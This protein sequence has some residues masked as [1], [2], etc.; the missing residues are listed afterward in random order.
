M[1][2]YA[3]FFLQDKYKIYFPHVVF[4]F[5][6]ISRTKLS[7]NLNFSDLFRKFL[8]VRENLKKKR[9]RKRRKIGECTQ[10]REI[11]E[12]SRSLNQVKLVDFRDSYSLCHVAVKKTVGIYRIGGRRK[13]Y[14]RSLKFSDLYNLL[15]SLISILP[16]LDT[17]HE[18][19]QCVLK[20]SCDSTPI[21][22][23]FYLMTWRQLW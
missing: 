6:Y 5:S 10:E 1:A 22:V 13:G 23:S 15:K 19:K 2:F 14:H 9:K 11:E 8:H 12:E 21:V 16:C 4:F 20:L 3:I 7:W 17:G 18:G